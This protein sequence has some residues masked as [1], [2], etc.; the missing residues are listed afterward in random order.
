MGTLSSSDYRRSNLYSYSDGTDDE[1]IMNVDSRRRSLISEICYSHIFSERTSL[2][3]GYQ[4]T[5]SRSTN[6]YLT[7]DYKPVLTENNNY[8]Y[9]NFGSRLIKY[10]S[11][12]RRERN[13]S[14]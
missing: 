11:P 2:S 4:N 3:A 14:G 1:Y 10:M 12:C 6:T 8:V 9:V 7:T 13:F 5:L